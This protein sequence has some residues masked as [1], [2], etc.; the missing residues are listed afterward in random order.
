MLIR[1]LVLVGQHLAEESLHA[2]RGLASKNA[3]WG[4]HS[5]QRAM[6]CTEELISHHFAI[7]YTTHA[8]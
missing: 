2:C 1:V 4:Q 5:A 3:E 8:A 7:K 6:R